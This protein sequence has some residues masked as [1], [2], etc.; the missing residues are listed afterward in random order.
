MPMTPSEDQEQF[1]LVNRLK[2]WVANG[3]AT[4]ISI[5]KEVGVSRNTVNRWVNG[6]RAIKSGHRKLLA[7]MERAIWVDTHISPLWAKDA[8]SLALLTL[9]KHREDQ[10]A[11]KAA[12][13]VLDML[14]KDDHKRLD[15]I[16]ATL[17][18]FA[19]LPVVPPEANELIEQGKQLAKSDSDK[20]RLRLFAANFELKALRFEPK[21]TKAA[22]KSADDLCNEYES[23]FKV[24]PNISVLFNA[25]EVANE[26]ALN[27]RAVKILDRIHKI[28][29]RGISDACKTGVF[30]VHESVND[31]SQLKEVHRKWK[32]YI[33]YL[34]KLPIYRDSNLSHNNT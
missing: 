2:E 6:K 18:I 17:L 16:L 15:V 25:L 19:P 7:Q 14:P 34:V 30:D 4:E 9:L 5:A 21:L 31:L 13:T 12:L 8:L 22:K 1:E 23:I 3:F 20:A 29:D 24:L 27:E 10:I 33:S 28:R 11:Q 32:D 26:F